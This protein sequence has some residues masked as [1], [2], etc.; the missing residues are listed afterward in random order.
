ML[1]PKAKY[2]NQIHLTYYETNLR[3][4]HDSLILTIGIKRKN[5]VWYINL[6][7][8]FNFIVSFQYLH[9]KAGDHKL[10]IP[11]EKMFSSQ[12]EG[13]VHIDIN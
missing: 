6:T 3:I 8:F 9:Y 13:I 11:K 12:K 4:S 7:F 5:I 1:G 10:Q 2:R